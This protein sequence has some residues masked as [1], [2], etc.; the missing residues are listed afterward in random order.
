MLRRLGVF[1]ATGAFVGYAP[2][3]PGTFG[4][5]LGLAVLF[6]VRY[7]Q[8]PLAEGATLVL[9]AGVGI[10]SASEA[11]RHFGRTDPGYIVIDEV[12]GML[13]TLAFLPVNATGILVAFLLFRVFD[14]VKPWPARRFERLHGGLGVMLDDVMAG[15]YAHLV[16]WGIVRLLPGV[17]A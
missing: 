3:A 13:V 17:L 15:V 1:V 8:S 12:V 5:A 9:L 16:M 10:W 11:E 14:V 4:S 2:V 6:V 7:S